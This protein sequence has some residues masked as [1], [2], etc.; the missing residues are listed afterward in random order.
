MECT[1]KVN[2]LTI[3]SQAGANFFSPT[4]ISMKVTGKRD[5][6][7]ELDFTSV[8]IPS[9][10][11]KVTGKWGFRMGKGNRYFKMARI[12]KAIFT[13]VSGMAKESSETMMG[14]FMRVLL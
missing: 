11:I 4:V 2:G 3:T 8:E 6:L 12:I 10:D 5:C 9:G 1:I 14:D 13:K 7:K